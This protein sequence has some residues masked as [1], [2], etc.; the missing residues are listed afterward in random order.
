MLVVVT[1][2]ITTMAKAFIGIQFIREFLTGCHLSG[3]DGRFEAVAICDH[4]GFL[5]NRKLRWKIRR[6][7]FPIAFA[8]LIESFDVHPI[9]RNQVH[10]DHEPQTAYHL[11][12][13]LNTR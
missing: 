4:L 3:N 5:I 7:A 8:L 6:K 9:Q 12:T 13:T 10:I 11:D 1:S 2:C